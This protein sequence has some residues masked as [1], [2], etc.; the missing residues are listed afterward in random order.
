[1]L[2]HF[3]NRK[4]WSPNADAKNS[5]FFEEDNNSSTNPWDKDLSK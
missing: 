3:L 2:L 5:E 1:M 4:S